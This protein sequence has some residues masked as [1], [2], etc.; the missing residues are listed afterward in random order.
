MDP[1]KKLF[2][3]KRTEASYMSDI[4][5]K[6]AHTPRILYSG[7]SLAVTRTPISMKKFLDKKYTYEKF[8][9]EAKENKVFSNRLEFSMFYQD[10]ETFIFFIYLPGPTKTQTTKISKKETFD[11]IDTIYSKFLK[12]NPKQFV[13]YL[14]SELE[15]NTKEIRESIADRKSNKIHFY[16]DENFAS[17]IR[18]HVFSP[19]SYEY[20][21]PNKT[22]EFTHQED[23][24]KNILPVVGNSDPF[25]M[26]INGDLN[27]IIK[28]ELMNFI[29]SIEYRR[30]KNI[31]QL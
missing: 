7:T 14:I 13:F 26:A 27:A 9:E 15:Y 12:H 19:L 28:L 30:V 8:V 25:I 5:N 3:M 6:G 24:V 17:D 10:D 2:L 4:I 29:P 18:Q 21:P 22:K 31:S 11:Y 1:H 20:I 23:I 16:M